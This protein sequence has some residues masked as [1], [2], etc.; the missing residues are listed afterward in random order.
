MPMQPQSAARNRYV[1][2]RGIDFDENMRV[3][4]SHLRRY[5]DGPAKNNPLWQRFWDRLTA[6]EA[7]D[8]EQADKLLLLHSHTYYLVELFEEH[9]DEAALRDLSKL[10]T[11]CF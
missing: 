1:T 9:N 2:F 3:V 11:E 6:L 10:E 7:G 8:V 4:L 5:T